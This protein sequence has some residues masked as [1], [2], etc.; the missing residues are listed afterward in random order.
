MGGANE[1]F[2]TTQW[3]AILLARTADPGRRR[4]VVG[5]LLA[6]YWKPVYCYLR[7]KGHDNESAKD[8]AQGFF[9]EVVLGRELIQQADRERGRFRT[10]L[11]TALDRYV[12]SAHRAEVAQ[13]RRPTS[14]VVPLEVVD[15]LGD[16]E[17]SHTAT[18]EEAFNYAWASALLDEVLA[19]VE[20]ECRRTGTDRHWEVFHARVVRPIL[21]DVAAPG[22]EELRATYGIDSP[23]RVSNMIVTVKRRFQTVL[24][25]RV[26]ELVGSDLEVDSEIRELMT[27]LARGGGGA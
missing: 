10:L 19:E 20:A 16:L 23:A 1:V 14:E 25:R 17:L 26:R 18:P 8:Y 12:T 6:Q 27:A 7:R 21:G 5:Q 4:A 24:K 2:R 9:H 22:I 3:S 13:K 11:L 15:A